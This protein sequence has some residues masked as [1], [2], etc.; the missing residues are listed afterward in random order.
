MRE[1]NHYGIKRKSYN[2]KDCTFSFLQ[3]LCSNKIGAKI[4]NVQ[5][6]FSCIEQ[7][8]VSDKQI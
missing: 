4:C 3:L 5:Q 2:Q 7:D 1:A 8:V 6:F